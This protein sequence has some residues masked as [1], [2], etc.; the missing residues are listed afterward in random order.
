MV[1]H[2]LNGHTKLVICY[3][4]ENKIKSKINKKTNVE[5]KQQMEM[6]NM[7]MNKNILTTCA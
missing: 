1:V 7:L 4:N 6:K 3:E 5:N 2:M